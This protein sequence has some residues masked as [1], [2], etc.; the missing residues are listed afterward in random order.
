MN[1]PNC[2]SEEVVIKFREKLKKY[3][4][5][6]LCKTCGDLKFPWKAL[7][8]IVF[9]WPEIIPEKQGSIYIPDRIKSIFK[10]SRGIVMSSGKG[11]IDK[12]TGRFVQ[13]GLNAGD[14]VL[15]DNTIP[16]QIDVEATDGKKYT[17][18]MCSILDISC[19]V[20]E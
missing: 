16:W 11:C 1:C 12:R 20:E 6:F 10:R 5:P 3:E 15:Y 14:V 4:V 13:S 2:G 7:K 19:C 9:I 8:G 17:I 18:D